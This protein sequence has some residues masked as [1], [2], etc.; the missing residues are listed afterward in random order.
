M[1]KIVYTKLAAKDIQKIKA[2]GLEKKAK[3]LIEII[4]KD[5]FHRP[6]A[7]EAL[8]G[9]LQGYFSRRINIQ[10]RLIYQVFNTPIKEDDIEYSGII[11]IIRLWTHY[12][13][14]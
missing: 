8:V 5:P 3:M 12:D 1:Y 11:K 13:S 14:L 2:A 10:H 4:R 6:P 7:F 9:D